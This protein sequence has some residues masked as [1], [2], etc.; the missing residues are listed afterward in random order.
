MIESKP[1]VI[2]SQRF[3]LAILVGML[4]G[5]T[6]TIFLPPACFGM[7]VGVGVAA[8]IAKAASPKEGALVGA[9]VMI[10]I[11]I[12]VILW[13]NAQT[14]TIQS[15][16]WLAALPF[17]FLAWLLTLGL[18]ALCGLLVGLLLR[19]TRNKGWIA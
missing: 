17:V 15:M 14:K 18:G 7:L 11:G 1:M 6:L 12:Y 9:I 10:P 19:F 16:G 13:T 8:Y 3:L 4:I 5:V 2:K